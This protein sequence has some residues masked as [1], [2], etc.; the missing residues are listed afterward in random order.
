MAEIEFNNNLSSELMRILECDQI[1][2]G[3]DVGYQICKLL[4]QFHPLGGKLVEKPITMAMCK[5]RSYEVETD[6]DER[7]VNAF[8]EVWKRMCIDEKIRNF[9]FLSRCYGAAAI[10]VGTEGSTSDS[11]LPDFG[12]KEAD[13]FINVWDPLNTA[14]SIV[15][16]QDPNSPE[17]Q[18][19][20]KTLAV[21][22]QQWHSSRTQKV[23]HGT[24]IYLEYQASTFGFT[25]RS[26][27]QRVLYPMKS[28]IQTMIANNLVSKKAGVLVAKTKQNGSVMNGIVAAA[29]RRKREDVKLSENE[30]VLSIGVEDSIESLNL[31][32]IDKALDT[33]RNNIISDIA[34][35]SDVPAHLIK[36]EAFANGFGEGKEDSKSVSQYIDGVRQG[37]EPVMFFFERIIQYIAWNED[38]YIAL[39]SEYPDIITDDYKTTFYLWRREFKASWVELDED[40]PDKQRES[41][42]K[43]VKEASGI[44]AIL[45]PNLDPENRATTAE[46]LASVINSTDSYGDT[47]L[48]LDVEALAAYQPPPPVQGDSY[49]NEE[50]TDEEEE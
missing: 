36:D 43:M 19:A 21:Q 9:F 1:E 7:V 5:P 34:A 40:S 41:D 47:P 44:Y 13:V 26:V 17:F 38:F 23:F 14:G 20:K 16:S 8:E 10:G 32:N 6:P 27:F 15:T 35:G 50:K 48:M 18:Q 4:W 42:S 2:P 28:Y 24:P 12:L 29:T 39:K 22:G 37:I 30:G 45:A 25:G 31:Q 49:A 11:A 3:A 46:W 33:S